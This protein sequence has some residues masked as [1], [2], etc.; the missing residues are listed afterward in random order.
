MNENNELD[1][2]PPVSLTR[3]LWRQLL[4]NLRNN[5]TRDHLPPLQ[6]TSR[7]VDVGMLPGDRLSLP[8]YKTVFT[9]LG[10]VISPESLPPLILESQ[11]MD[12]GE[13]IG[14]QMSHMWW[15]SLLR[16]L[17]DK[18]APERLPALQLTSAPMNLANIAESTFLQVPQWSSAI[19][20]PKVFLPDKPKSYVAVQLAPPRP[21][22]KPDPAEI[23]FV[24]I[25]EQDVRRD[26]R[27]SQ[28]RA[29]IWI[30]VAVAQV[31]LLVGGLILP[32]LKHL[33]ATK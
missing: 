20:T 19:S 25:L 10:D 18:V 23:E 16:N 11:P 6:L 2:L 28:I 4:V 31:L 17:A 26:L 27:R 12:V 7:P 15:S 8:W 21:M 22:P 14:D 3:P 32:T 5:L 33:L 24:N 9:N 30:S 1:L 29:R 13:L